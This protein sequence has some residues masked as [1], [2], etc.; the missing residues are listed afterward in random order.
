[1]YGESNVTLGFTG[2]GAPEPITFKVTVNPRA[3]ADNLL[4]V[5][6]KTSTLDVLRNDTVPQS[7]TSA[8]IV[9]FTQPANGTLVA[10]S[11]PGTLRYTPNTGFTGNDLFTYT[12]QYN[13]GP[14]VTNTGFVTVAPYVNVDAVHTDIRFDYDAGAWSS[15]LHADLAFG[16]PNQ[17]GSANPTILDYDEALLMVNPSSI[18]TLPSTLNTTQFNFLGVDR[19]S[20]FGT[21]LSLKRLEFCGPVSAPKA[22]PPVP[23]RRIRP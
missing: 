8:T 21:Y 13:L 2:A 19:M 23:L 7:G 22:L 15:E 17:G 5:A 18:I 4:G 16:T 1:M 10:G 14:A 6:G 11:V 9:S 3:V 12:S 20:R